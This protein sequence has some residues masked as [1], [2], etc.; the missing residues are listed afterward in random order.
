MTRGLWGQKGLVIVMPI[1]KIL[2]GAKPVISVPANFLFQEH[3]NLVL[4]VCDNHHDV[5]EGHGGPVSRFEVIL[6]TELT[7]VA[8]QADDEDE[9]E[10][11]ES[12]SIDDV[13]PNPISTLDAILAV[14]GIEA[15]A[16]DLTQAWA[17][18]VAAYVVGLSRCRRRKVRS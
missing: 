13:I 9:L 10:E 14:R 4:S 11:W 12:Y 18:E 7:R 3:S 6:A 16:R 5:F 15:A 17:D 2:L 1:I 8:Q